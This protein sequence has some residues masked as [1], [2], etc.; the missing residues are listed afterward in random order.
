LTLLNAQLVSAGVQGFLAANT[1]ERRQ[2]VLKILASSLPPTIRVYD[3]DGL[4]VYH[5]LDAVL[6]KALSHAAVYIEVRYPDGRA[7]VKKGGFGPTSL[8][9]STEPSPK[10]AWDRLLED[11]LV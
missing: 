2:E 8:Q 10:S 6:P 11:D 5:D 7:E 1:A 3:R 4:H 9:Q